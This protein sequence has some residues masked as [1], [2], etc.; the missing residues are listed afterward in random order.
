MSSDQ[1]TVRRWSKNSKRPS[2][3]WTRPTEPRMLT[4]RVL[5]FLRCALCLAMALTTMSCANGADR[6]ACERDM[7][8]IHF[9]TQWQDIS[10]W[11]VSG[12]IMY[13]YQCEPGEPHIIRLGLTEDGALAP[14]YQSDARSLWYLQTDSTIAQLPPDAIPTGLFSR[15]RVLHIAADRESAYVRTHDIDRE[16]EYVRTQD[17]EIWQRHDTIS[18]SSPDP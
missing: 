7:E 16:S 10:G 17:I 11:C 8:D 4:N 2:C 18:C 3:L 14:R 12:T 5:R 13:E 6:V 9:T 1:H 15:E